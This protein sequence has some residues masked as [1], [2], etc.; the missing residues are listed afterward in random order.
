MCLLSDVRQLGEYGLRG[1]DSAYNAAST[2][3][4][5]TG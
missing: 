2:H 4:G 5:V 1:V 3:S